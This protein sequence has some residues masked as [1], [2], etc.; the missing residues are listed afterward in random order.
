MILFFPSY[1]AH[2]VLK[3]SL[4]LNRYNLHEVIQHQVASGEHLE[5]TGQAVT[6][7]PSQRNHG[8]HICSVSLYAIVLPTHPQLLLS[9]VV[10]HRWFTETARV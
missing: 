3:P 10:T 9:A 2:E 5:S 8:F 1:A 7:I 6:D 4:N